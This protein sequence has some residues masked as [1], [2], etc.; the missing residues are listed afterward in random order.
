MMGAATGRLYLSPPH[1][2]GLEQSYVD[3]AIA[4]NW[5]APLGPHVDAFEQEFAERLGIAHALALSSGTAAL[6]LALRLAGVGPG[7]EV[8]VST[9]TFVASVNPIVY[10]G[11][12][13]VLLDCEMRS[14]NMDPVLLE[15]ALKDRARVGRLPRAVVVVHLYGQTADM[16]PIRHLCEQYGVP[17]IEDAAEA[18]GADHRGRHAGT[19]GLAGVF[20]FN[21]NKIITTS[22][23]GMLVSDDGALVESAR[24][25]SAQAREPA[26]HYEHREI[27]YNYRLSNL[28][29]AVG[30]AQLTVLDERVEARRRNFARYVEEL[31]R[32]PGLRFMPE[33]EWGRHSRWLT[34]VTIDPESFG[35]DREAIRTALERENIEARPVWKPMHRQ[36]V[37]AG[38][39][40][41]GGATADLLF[42]TGI[43]LPSGSNLSPGEIGRVVDVIG[44]VHSSA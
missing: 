10:L 31:G 2:S 37:F 16:D 12:S 42:E 27:G 21:G 24:K 39:A 22:G 36:P 5:V 7:D 32:L 15:E 20:S 29:A 9:L 33:A 19:L 1:M 3:D 4:S 13:P 11:A 14:W 6:H 44:Q 26:N 30:R 34:C 35:S 8:F 41:F 43:C 38:A 23:G 25:L 18:L 17:V 40:T 28:L